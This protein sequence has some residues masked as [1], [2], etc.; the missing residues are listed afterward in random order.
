MCVYCSHICMC[1]H[2]YTHVQ[3]CART[4]KH[5]HTYARTHTS[6]ITH[7]NTHKHKHIHKYTQVHPHARTHIHIYWSL[8]VG[9]INGLRSGHSR[10]VILVN[11]LPPFPFSDNTVAIRLLRQHSSDLDV[12]PLSRYFAN[13]MM[14]VFVCVCL[15]GALSLSLCV[16]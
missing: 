6:T 7:T 11:H 1:K 13:I 5:A 9:K 16:C 2:A 14:D 8:T 3:L 10:D 15:F 12:R 4:T